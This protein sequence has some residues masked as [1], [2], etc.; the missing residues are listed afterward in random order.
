MSSYYLL[1]PTGASFPF[2]FVRTL[3]W[4]GGWGHPTLLTYLHNSL[5]LLASADHLEF[6]FVAANKKKVRYDRERRFGGM[7]M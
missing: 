4:E 2:S 5:R 6:S 7:M 1:P 3:E